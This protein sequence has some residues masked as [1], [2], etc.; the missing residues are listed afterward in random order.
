MVGAPASQ[1]PSQAAQNR[2]GRRTSWRFPTLE[3]V[4]KELAKG[5]RFGQGPSLREL[6]EVRCVLAS[7]RPTCTDRL[8]A[9]R[10]AMDDLENVP[11]LP[12]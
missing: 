1:P 6:S 9:R 2:C 7:P 12:W 5:E 11:P 8:L 10:E 4:K 3:R